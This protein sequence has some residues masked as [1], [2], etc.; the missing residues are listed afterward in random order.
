M[1][2]AVWQM[3]I[4]CHCLSIGQAGSEHWFSLCC[5]LIQVQQHI[6]L[7]YIS[8]SIHIYFLEISMWANCLCCKQGMFM[9]EI[10]CPQSPR[11]K[12]AAGWLYLECHFVF[13]W[14]D[15]TLSWIGFSDEGTGEAHRGAAPSLHSI[16]SAKT[17][18]H[19]NM[20]HLCRE[21]LPKWLLLRGWR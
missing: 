13:G 2:D 17:A 14:L 10:I 1:R 11:V 8:A 15:S 5:W 7:R 9:C 19:F 3:F 20:Q 6:W 12:E 21:S 18:L 16:S 4:V